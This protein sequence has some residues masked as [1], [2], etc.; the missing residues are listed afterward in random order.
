MKITFILGLLWLASSAYGEIFTW[1]DSK[2]I[3]HYANKADDVPPR[4]RTKVKTLYQE[5]KKTDAQSQALPVSGA[6]VTTGPSQNSTVVSPVQNAPAGAAPPNTGTGA[7]MPVG[8]AQQQTP[9]P[10]AAPTVKPV[11]PMQ[12]AGEQVQRKARRSRG[13]RVSSEE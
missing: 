6:N 8:P 9:L 10:A 3:A 5:P 13:S 12:Q 2:G 7:N 1:I 11:D 4:Y